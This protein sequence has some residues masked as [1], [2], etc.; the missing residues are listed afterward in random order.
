MVSKSLLLLISL[1]F[2]FSQGRVDNNY[3]HMESES[4]E[5]I[6][7]TIFT[8]IGYTNTLKCNRLFEMVYLLGELHGSY[9]EWLERKSIGKS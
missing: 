1:S 2:A 4:I 5:K 3:L 8:V 7:N 6:N 9:T